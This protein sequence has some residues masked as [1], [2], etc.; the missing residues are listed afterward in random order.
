MA[1]SGRSGPETGPGSLAQKLQ[2]DLP[3]S[4]Q[5]M[6]EEPPADAAGVDRLGQRS[7]R[8]PSL[9]KLFGELD[10]MPKR[11]PNAIEPPAT[12]GVGLTRDLQQ[13]GEFGTIG[14]RSAGCLDE[15][16]LAPRCLEGVELQR[17]I[18]G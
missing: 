7:Q 13:L 5:H 2:L 10:Q 6:K 3:Q 1:T 15:D 17:V 9:L 16:T 12:H 4:A 11:T 8:D 18:L 14:P